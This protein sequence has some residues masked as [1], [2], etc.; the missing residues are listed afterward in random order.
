MWISGFQS[1][2]PASSK[3]TRVPGSVLS[4]FAKTHPAEPAPIMT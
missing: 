4:R 2:P 3:M 1:R